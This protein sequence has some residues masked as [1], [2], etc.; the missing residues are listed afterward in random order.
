MN[1][2][3]TQ[4]IQ[5]FLFVVLSFCYPNIVDASRNTEIDPTEILQKWVLTAR[6]Q[7]DNFPDQ[8]KFATGAVVGFTTSKLA[9]KS[10]V[11][12]VKI[13][14]AAFVATEVLEAAGI[15]ELDSF[16]ETETSESIKRKAL[17]K[18]GDIRKSIRN[19]LDGKNIKRWMET[20]KMGSFGVAA[21]AFFGFLL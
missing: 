14:G 19:R 9:V 20:D 15:L 11:K 6:E 13:A 18:I 10:A 7:Y 3:K 17:S 21:G 2:F 1:L 16:A 12:F 5:F 8:G 4:L